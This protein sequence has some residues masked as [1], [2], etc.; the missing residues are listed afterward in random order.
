MTIF[1]RNALISLTNFVVNGSE[2]QVFVPFKGVEGSRKIDHEFP[3]LETLNSLNGPLHYVPQY[4]NFN[5]Y[6]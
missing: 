3:F 5:M 6:D 2:R 1:L 4:L